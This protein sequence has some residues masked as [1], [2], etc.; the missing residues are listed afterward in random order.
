[1]YIQG[2]TELRQ[3]N[4][5]LR[6]LNTGAHVPEHGV[7]EGNHYQKTKDQTPHKV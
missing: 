2:L 4:A 1:M 7:D 5:A 3:I 6:V